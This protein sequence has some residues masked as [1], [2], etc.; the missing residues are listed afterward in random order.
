ME[1]PQQEAEGSGRILIRRSRK[2]TKTGVF[3]TQEDAANQ[4][5]AR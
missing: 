2:N 4:A 1:E 5:K 3:W